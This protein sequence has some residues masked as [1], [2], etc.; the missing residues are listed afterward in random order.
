MPT[1]PEA[2]KS[3]NPLH[4][5]LI[6]FNTH[7]QARS[8][9]GNQGQWDKFTS[10]YNP[11]HGGYALN[12]AIRDTNLLNNGAFVFDTNGGGVDSDWD[13]FYTLQPELQDRDCLYEQIMNFSVGADTVIDK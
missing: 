13:S 8:Q 2:S 11:E 9:G 4:P 1:S 7:S 6:D 12:N 10:E 5:P 3:G